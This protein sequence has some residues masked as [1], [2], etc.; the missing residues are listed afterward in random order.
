MKKQELKNV[1]LAAFESNC[2]ALDEMRKGFEQQLERKRLELQEMYGVEA[3]ADL[4]TSLG[5][6][7]NSA[8]AR[9]KSTHT[10][11]VSARQ[12][13]LGNA[14]AMVKALLKD[15]KT[16]TSHDVFVYMTEVVRVSEKDFTAKNASVY[17]GQH[18]GQFGLQRKSEKQG[19][20]RGGALKVYSRATDSKP[21]DVAGDGNFTDIVLAK[22]VSTDGEMTAVKLKNELGVHAA[23]KTLSNLGAVLSRLASQGKIERVKKGIYRPK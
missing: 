2:R 23:D 16:F 9:R 17:I 15:K 22:I 19:K 4:V 7:G 18:Y 20:G 13:F 8:P 1:L 12:L 6:S 21:D 5:S 3:V 10:R 14:S 11:E